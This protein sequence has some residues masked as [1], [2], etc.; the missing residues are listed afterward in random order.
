MEPASGGIAFHDDH[1]RSRGVPR[2]VYKHTVMPVDILATVS[3]ILPYACIGRSRSAGAVAWPFLP[4]D[5]QGRGVQFAGSWRRFGPLDS[6]KPPF[7]LRPTVVVPRCTHN[8]HL[9]NPGSIS[10]ANSATFSGLPVFQPPC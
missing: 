9:T 10:K 1:A 8:R 6:R 4:S 5:R 3:E 7:R 2:A